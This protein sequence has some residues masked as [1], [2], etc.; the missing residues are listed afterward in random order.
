[1][2]KKTFKDKYGNTYDKYEK[3]INCHE[4]AYHYINRCCCCRDCHYYCPT[5]LTDRLYSNFNEKGFKTFE[6]KAHLDNNL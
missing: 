1:M 3:C 6:Y 5:C 2:G 4:K